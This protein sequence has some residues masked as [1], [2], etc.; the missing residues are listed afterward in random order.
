MLSF[1]QGLTLYG[2]AGMGTVYQLHGDEGSG[3]SSMAAA[4][5]RNYMKATGE[6]AAYF[7]FERRLKSWYLRNM[8]CDQG[9][10]FIDRPDGW[11]QSVQ[12]AI[13]FMNQGV[14]LF[15]FDSI[16]RMRSKVDLDLIKNG[17]AFKVQPG[18]HARAIQ[19]FYDIILPYIAG[20]DG[21]LIVVNQTRSR[22][23]MSQEAQMAAKGYHTVTNLNYTLPGGRANRYAVSV[24]V[25]NKLA[26]AY[27]PG[28][29][30]DDDPFILE[31]EATRGEE[32]LA[33]E[34]RPGRRGKFP[35]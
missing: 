23:E 20:V 26:R 19:Q 1:D 35:R 22:I 8:G 27:K 4:T 32:Y 29:S 34:I 7:D 16:S 21:T 9:M 24:M 18:T 12:R 2:I 13:D 17:D 14:R 15:V 30:P 11:E 28:K 31:P 25:E 6:P 3:K 10:M 33:L 5:V